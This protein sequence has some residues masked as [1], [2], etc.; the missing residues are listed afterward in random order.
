[1]ASQ[2][3]DII[4]YAYWQEMPNPVKM[5][6]LS[7]QEARGHLTWS[8][9]YNE[10]W[11][12]S[13][14]QLLLDPDLQWYS[15]PQY[16]SDQKPNFGVF[17]DSMPDSWGRTLMK[18]REALLKTEDE[19]RRRLT[20]L[21]FLLGVYDPAR[22]GG[23]RFKLEEDG[24]FLDD[25]EGKSIPPITDVREL[26]MGADLVESDEDSEAVRKWL[27][28][29]LAPGSSLGGARP[30]SSVV[31][32]NGEL[33]IAKFPSRQDTIDKGAWEFVAWELATSAGITVPEA[34][35]ELISGKYHTFFTKRFD[36]NG[37][38][39]IHFASAM[40]MTGHF[41]TEIRDYTPSYL[42]LAEFIQFHGASPDEDLH[43]LWR[44]IVFNIAISNTDDHLRN[45]GFIIE[46][47]GWRLSPAYDMNPSIDKAGLAL[48]IDLELNAL[49]YDLARSV[50]EYFNLRKKE[51]DTIIEEVQ[52]AVSNWEEVAI[53]V[54]VPSAQ[55]RI[56]EAAFN[57]E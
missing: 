41:E 44:R 46:E 39:R 28:I 17:L 3:T 56:M 54:G 40:T 42:E 52:D 8:F 14:S 22:M 38:E 51:M 31:D 4:V 26:Q 48:N 36:R 25:D 20:D 18:K 32:E 5:G 53:N 2:K 50:G 55:R 6:I 13:Q 16:S 15:G 49:D 1:M 24:P 37:G 9:A 35:V 11:L 57:V 7:A 29:L 19:Q 12:D 33:W 30:K 10:E 47:D 27:Q 34:R 45:H 21:D 43:E 23:L